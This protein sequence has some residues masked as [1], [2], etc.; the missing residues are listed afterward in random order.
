M[1]NTSESE[2]IQSPEEKRSTKKSKKR[3]N[4][5]FPYKK[6]RKKEIK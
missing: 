6:N 3:D 1:P 4:K 2:Y 5:G